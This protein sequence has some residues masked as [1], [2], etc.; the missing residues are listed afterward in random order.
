MLIAGDDYWI[1]LNDRDTEGA[2]EWEDRPNDRPLGAF[3]DWDTSIGEP[4]G[5]NGDDC[6]RIELGGLRWRDSDCAGGSQD[7]HYFACE[8][9]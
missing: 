4:N 5:G 3:D 2:F 9:P 6:V 7:S 8:A 1:G